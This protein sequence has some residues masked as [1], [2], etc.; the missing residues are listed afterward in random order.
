L[1][2]IIIMKTTI[3]RKIQ[4]TII[5]VLLITSFHVDAQTN[6]AVY[7]KALADSLGADE[8]GMK[9]YV[10]VMLK[11]GTNTTESKAATDSLFAGHMQNIGRLVEMKKLVVAG[12]LQKNDKNYRGIFIL[13]VKTLEDA[14]ALI[15]T[16]PAVKA[17]LLDADMF[18]WYG[19]A[20][21]T[22][23]LPY[24]EKVQKTKF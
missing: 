9:M 18:L 14:K 12:P 11:T 3:A 15:N 6:N 24:H 17:K 13:N 2:K 16:D 7:D 19:S 8:Y 10:L 1:H 4:R 21:L 22:I 5:L 23:Y 20:A